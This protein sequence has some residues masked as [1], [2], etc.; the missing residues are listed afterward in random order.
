[1]IIY[2]NTKAGFMKDVYDGVI[3][4]KIEQLILEKMKRR[5]SPGEVSSW[6]NSLRDMHMVMV[7]SPIPDDVEVAVE[8]K[9]PNSNKRVDFIVTGADHND[10]D[11]AVII[12]LKQW[13]TIIK[14]DVKDAI[15]E[16]WLSGALR[17]TVHPSY[18]AWS[19]ASMIH[20]YNE[21][22]RQNNIK[23]NPCAFLHN[24]E[25]SENDPLIDEKYQYYID[26]API[27]TKYDREELNNF[28]SNFIKKPKTTILDNIEHGKIKPSKALQDT[29]VS[30]L[31]GNQEFVLL[32]D[33]KV[34]Y[35]MV[36]FEVK[37]LKENEKKVIIVNG[38]PGTGKSVLAINL[39]SSILQM[40]KNAI[41]VTKNSAPR[42]VYLEKLV[43]GNYK[44]KAIDFLFR[45]PE[46]FYALDTNSFDCILVDEA[47][48][49]REKSGFFSNR[50]TNQIKEIINAAKVS[51]F[52][53]DDFQQVTTKDIG[54]TAEIKVW[55][56]RLNVP[57]I[58]TELVSQFR[59]NG[60][61]GYLAWIDNVLEIKHT[62]WDL[63]DLDYDVRILDSPQEVRDLIF[64]KNRI[65]NKA[66]LLAGYCWKWEKSERNNPHH[67][68]IQIEDFEMPWNFENT[69]T[70]AIDKESVNEIGCIHTSQGLEFDYVGVIIGDD[71]RYENNMVVTDFFK[72]ATTDQSIRGLKGLYRT[73]KDKALRE[74]DRIIRNTYRTLLTRGQKGC[75]IYCTDSNL[76][77]YLK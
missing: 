75:Y 45:S 22:V 6:M 26:K 21:N 18:Q 58:E 74:A 19:Y 12:E 41:Y 32:D 42:N 77:N 61:D 50:G 27:F 55:A 10:V 23:L 36:N 20:D 39:L 59:C 43:Q 48:R 70:W 76:S 31:D 67:Y 11:H 51:V 35:E 16:T 17:E 5:T 72:R 13:S 34:I 47:H 29:M 1:M 52:F 38:G 33:Q 44:K 37:S 15:V 40:E 49:L 9:I 53:I 8:Y 60:S 24:Y 28:I 69:A 2:Q 73:N 64:E 25:I 66:R 65:N 30:L 62:D 54:S 3:E 46:I 14:N 57:Y 4:R 7:N 63:I 71:L 56:N 68:D